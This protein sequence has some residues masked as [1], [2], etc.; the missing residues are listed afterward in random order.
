MIDTFRLKLLKTAAMLSDAQVADTLGMVYEHR[1]GTGY[2][3]VVC[4]HQ[5]GL[6]VWYLPLPL[7]VS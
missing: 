7:V 4:R 3:A 2:T 5:H 1:D 6:L